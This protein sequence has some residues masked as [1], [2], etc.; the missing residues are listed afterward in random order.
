[1]GTRV[2]PAALHAVQ[3]FLLGVVLMPL[4]SFILCSIFA[5]M[6]LIPLCNNDATQQRLF[7]HRQRAM[8]PFNLAAALVWHVYFLA[9]FLIQPFALLAYELLR[10]CLPSTRILPDDTHGG[11]HSAP[12]SEAVMDEDLEQ[13]TGSIRRSNTGRL[14]PAAVRAASTVTLLQRQVQQQRNRYI[15]FESVWAALEGQDGAVRAGDVRLVSLV[16]LMGLAEK[17]GTLP[18]RQDLPEEAFLDTTKLKAIQANARRGY[19]EMIFAD[20]FYALMEGKDVLKNFFRLFATLCGCN[21]QRNADKLLPI[22]AISYCWLEA[23]HPDREGRQLKLMCER[24]KALYGGRGLLGACRDYGFSDMGVFLDWASIY[25]KN[26]ALFD[27]KET[28]EA[29]S[30]AQSTMEA[31]VSFYGGEQYAKSRSDDEQAAF[32]RALK[33]TMDLWYAH[34]GITVVMLTKLPDGDKNQM[35]SYESRG[36]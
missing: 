17:G 13:A 1:M 19:S 31:H 23:A 30:E 2:G 29:K 16:W 36:W 20:H 27:P 24:L 14:L 4:G 9:A 12:S 25:Q 18:R 15:G 8:M 6:V 11:S 7:T 5:P 34:A 35:R 33:W 22:I 3:V 26:P 28:P 32:G 21:N 10:L